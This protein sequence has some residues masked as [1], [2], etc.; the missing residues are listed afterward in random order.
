[1]TAL[2][3]FMDTLKQDYG[4]E[5]PAISALIEKLS[6]QQMMDFNDALATDNR[7]M[8]AHILGLVRRKREPASVTEDTVGEDVLFPI[9]TAVK[10]SG[11]NGKVIR[12]SLP[13]GLIG[14][15]IGGKMR[16]C[17][18]KEIEPLNESDEQS[19]DWANLDQILRRAGLPTTGN[20]NMMVMQTTIP[21]MAAATDDDVCDPDICL[22]QAMDALE[23]LAAAIPGVR[24]QDAANLRRRINEIIN[25]LN[26]TAT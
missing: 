2:N 6:G 13:G 7:K 8:A 26:E 24:M 21:V 3:T 1:M 16:P 19:F 14:V 15:D 10:V 25:R 22:Q 20:S 5:G 12:P 9:G 23:Q 11:K 4:I 17:T 18:R